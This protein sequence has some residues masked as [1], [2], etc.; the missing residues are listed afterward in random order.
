MSRVLV[1]GAHGLVGRTLCSRLEEAGFTVR[2]ASRVNTAPACPV[3]QSVVGDIT[4]PMDWS[5]ALTGVQL[6]VHA[7]ARTHIAP[8]DPDGQRLLEADVFATRQLAAAAR[9][10][11][12]SR[13]IYLSSIKVNGED[14]GSNPFTADRTPRPVDPYG[15][16]KLAGEI[17]VRDAAEGGVMEVAIVRPPLIYGPGVRANFLR[18]M[19]WIDREHLLPLGAVDNRRSLVSVWNLA[20]LIVKLLAHPNAAGRVWLVSDCEDPSTPELIRRMATVLGRR[21]R[22]LSVPLP[23]LRACARIAGRGAEVSRL[24][25]SLVVDASPARELLNWHPAISLDEGLARTAAWYRTQWP[26]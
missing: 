14:S 25:G 2:A 12:V 15:R 19:R 26:A 17:A 24:T 18:L 20:D 16:S 6:V 7:A 5:S 11:G 9:H 13:F 23:V 1:T 10:H 22:L 8:D 21:A 3:E 4:R